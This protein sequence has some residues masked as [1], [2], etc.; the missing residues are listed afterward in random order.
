MK[1]MVKRKTYQAIEK[2]LIIGV[3]IIVLG[4]ISF[5]FFSIKEALNS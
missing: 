5:V 3:I 1:I 2:C 4:I